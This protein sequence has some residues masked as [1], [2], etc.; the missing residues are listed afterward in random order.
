MEK[1]N[2]K[3]EEADTLLHDTNSD[4]KPLYRIKFQNPGNGGLREF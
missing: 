3:Q 1:E 2:Y 4:T